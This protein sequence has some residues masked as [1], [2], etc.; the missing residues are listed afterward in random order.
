M[1]MDVIVCGY[2]PEDEVYICRTYMDAPDVDGYVFIPSGWQLMS[3]D[4]IKVKIT[5]SEGYD[6]VGE[7]VN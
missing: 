2:L 3:G 5:G 4:F 1:E 7:V 6:L